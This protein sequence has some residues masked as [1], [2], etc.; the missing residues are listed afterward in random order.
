MRERLFTVSHRLQP[1]P[2][3]YTFSSK[4][5]PVV[6]YLRMSGRWLGGLGFAIGSKV[7]VSAQAGRLVLELAEPAAEVAEASAPPIVSGN[8]ASLRPGRPDLRR[9]RA[10]ARRPSATGAAD[11]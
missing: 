3:R 2:R 5:G 8:D 6:P 7:R 4:T 10:R 9:R 1:D 11:A